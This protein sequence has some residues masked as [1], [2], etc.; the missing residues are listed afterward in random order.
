MDGENVHK[1]YEKRKKSE[2]SEGE[3]RVYEEE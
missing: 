2:R 1:V 3:E